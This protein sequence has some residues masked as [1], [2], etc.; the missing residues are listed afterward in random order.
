VISGSAGIAETILS[1]HPK[2][3]AIATHPIMLKK[4]IRTM[5]ILVPIIS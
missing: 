4:A 3:K 5:A 1:F 2:E